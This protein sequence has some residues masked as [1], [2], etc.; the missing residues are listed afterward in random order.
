MNGEQPGHSEEAGASDTV[1]PSSRMATTAMWF[2]IIGI[3]FVPFAIA[4][5]V[6][7][8]RALGQMDDTAEGVAG[9]GTVTHL[10]LATRS[11]PGPVISSV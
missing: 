8:R 9:R 2:G 10:R 1:S 3:V 5:L 11:P 4:A 7:G 6:M